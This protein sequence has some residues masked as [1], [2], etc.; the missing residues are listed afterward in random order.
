MTLQ[1]K[2]LM[3]GDW[4]YI[5]DYPIKFLPKKIRPEHFVRSLVEFE[6]IPLTAEI[7]AKNGWQPAILNG[8][9]GRKGRRIDGE[10]LDKDKLPEG[11]DNALNFAQWSIDKDFQYHHLDLYMWRG[12]ISIWI[13]YVHELQHIF[14]LYKINKPIKL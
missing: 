14:N 3:I 13:E 6:P 7:L 1:P 8:R 9:Y 5:K 12:H 10:Y 2:D 4:V 11:V